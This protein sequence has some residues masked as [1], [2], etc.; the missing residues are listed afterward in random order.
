MLMVF[1]FRLLVQGAFIINSMLV[2]ESKQ[3]P[4]SQEEKNAIS[5]VV[6]EAQTAPVPG[7]GSL[8]LGGHQHSIDME[9]VFSHENL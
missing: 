2:Q 8:R 1:R 5:A 7:P 4:P 3:S 6:Q 9:S